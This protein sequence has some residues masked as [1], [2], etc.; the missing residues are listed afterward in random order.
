MATLSHTNKHTTLPQQHTQQPLLLANEGRRQQPY[1]H[2]HIHLASWPVCVCLFVMKSHDLTHKLARLDAVS[3]F[4][5]HPSQQVCCPLLQLS[6][7]LSLLL[8]PLAH[9]TAHFIQQITLVSHTHVMGKHTHTHMHPRGSQPLFSSQRHVTPGT[10]GQQAAADSRTRQPTTNTPHAASSLYTTQPAAA[11]QALS[12]TAAVSGVQH[13][14]CSAYMQVG[15]VQQSSWICLPIRKT[16]PP[17]AL[18][19][20]CC[21]WCRPQLYCPSCQSHNRHLSPSCLQS[22]GRR[23]RHSTA[24]QTQM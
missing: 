13:S 18:A 7:L 3:S 16:P 15:M 24:Q 21:Q 14:C 4:L 8:H 9:T 5:H 12:T 23:A 11:L 1:H 2:N 22:P 20:V 10:S 19:V 6:Q 17:V